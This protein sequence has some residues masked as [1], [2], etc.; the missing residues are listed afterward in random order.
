MTN[1]LTDEEVQTTLLDS[2]EV[3]GRLLK[4]VSQSNRLKVLGLLV[5][6]PKEFSYLL[7]ET[8]ITKTALANHITLLIQ[9][10][11]VKRIERGRYCITEDGSELLRATVKVYN[12]SKTRK[13]V[14]RVQLRKDMARFYQIEEEQ[15]TME[16]KMVSS[17]PRYQPCWIS[18]LGAIT[19]VL[20]ALGTNC[21]II[22]V[23]GY[24][25]YNFIVHVSKGTT[26]PSGPTAMAPEA[27]EEIRRGTQALG[28][29]LAGWFE[30]KSFPEKE[31]ELTPADLARAKTFFNRVKSVIEKDKPAIIWGIPVP[32]YGIVKGYRG[33]EYIVSTFRSLH[34]EEG[35]KEEQPI[36]YNALQAPGCLDLLYFIERIDIDQKKE[37]KIAIKRALNVTRGTKVAREHYVAGP[38]AYEEWASI[39]EKKGEIDVFGNSYIGACYHEGKDYAARFLRRMAMRYSDYPQ[40]KS[41]EEASQ[42]FQNAEKVLKRFTEL[43]P[44]LQFKEI[45]MTTENR[46]EGAK[47]LRDAKMHEE[48]AIGYLEEALTVW[49][50][51]NKRASK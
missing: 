20:Q 38:S 7:E 19:G 22:D 1:E 45:K 49:E 36:P 11:L 47:L 32:E 15:Q 5:N 9:S 34:L 46:K 29:K 4:T 40:K 31:G 37:D 24:S 18:Y 21:D 41:L 12:E 25:G 39:L 50:N 48:A 28:W 35:T 14:E 27:W 8:Y 51:V 30:S 23:G 3:I 2:L 16:E 26:C 6:N 43:F 10:G 42:A 13:E 44:S 17:D 33:D